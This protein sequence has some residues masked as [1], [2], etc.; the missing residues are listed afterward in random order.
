MTRSTPHSIPLPRRKADIRSHV[1]ERLESRLLLAV[2][3]LGTVND[4]KW[5]TGSNWTGGQVP[6]C[7][8]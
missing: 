3:W 2:T 4:H 7:H 6:R 5:S 8:R 1:L